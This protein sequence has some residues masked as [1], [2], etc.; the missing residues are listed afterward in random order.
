MSKELAL[1]T[2]GATVKPSA[3]EA[4]DGRNLPFSE[5]CRLAKVDDWGVIKI[6]NV[7]KP[8]PTIVD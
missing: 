1:L 2:R 5:F 3:A 7:G 4:L 8:A 6:K